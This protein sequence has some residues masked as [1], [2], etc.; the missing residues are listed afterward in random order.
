M[1]LFINKINKNNKNMYIEKIT[2]MF[3]NIQKTNK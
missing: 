1:Y 3:L 2:Y